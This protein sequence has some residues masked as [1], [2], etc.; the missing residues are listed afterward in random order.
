MRIK[1][2]VPGYRGEIEA[3]AC[4]ACARKNE[5]DCG[6]DYGLLKFMFDQNSDSRKT[7]VHATDLTGCLLRAFWSKTKE[8]AEYPHE[9]LMRSLGI[10][11]HGMLEGSADDSLIMELPVHEMGVHGRLDATYHILVDEDGQHVRIVDYK[12]TRWLRPS[13]LPYG[14][15]DLQVNIYAQLLR[16]ASYIVDSAAIQYI[17]LSGPSKCRTCKLP[18]VPVEDGLVCPNCGMYPRGAHL[19]AVTFE[20]TLMSEADISTFIESRRDNLLLS[21]EMSQDPEAEPSYLCSYCK[22]L[23]ECPVGL[24]HLGR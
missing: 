5:N 16:S 10:I 9:M 13:N 7:E 19:G 3:G 12:T 17:D 6:Y 8:V 4:L 11:T 23:E 21:L 2:M 14:S 24:R 22:F 18:V 15:H 20:V 1:C